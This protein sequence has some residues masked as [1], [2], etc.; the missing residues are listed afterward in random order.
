M[1]RYETG[2]LLKSHALA[3]V[4]AV[5]CQGV[6]G[7]GIAYQFKEAF[8]KNYNIYRDS[9]KKGDFKIGSILIVH[10]QGKLIVNFPSKD[11]WK[12]KS[13]YEYIAI[14]LE[15]LK[16]EIIKR[17]IDSIAIP[18]LGC[19]NGGLEWEVVQSMIIKTLGNLESVEIILFAP[20]AKEK[21]GLDKSAISVKHLLV[22][23]VF[24]RISNKYRYAL[25]SVFYMCSLLNNGSYFDFSIKHGRPYSQEL[26]DVINGLKELRGKYK[27]DFEGFIENYINTHL[28]KD[29]EAEFRRFLPSLNFSIEFLNEFSSKEDFVL[30]SKVLSD[31]Y[32]DPLVSY[33]SLD[34]EAEVLEKLI[35]KGIIHKNLLSE[36]E[37]VKF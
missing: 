14:G 3:L 17:N 7:K 32:D 18:P 27:Q 12:K 9:C 21:T 37:L 29:M 36:Y 10:E 28:T 6:M 31:V 34:R 35:T 5:N 33:D 25:N 20:P 4:N 22:H 15:K 16:S 2:N 19:G 1:I 13:Q 26:D 30:L 8:P 23:Y 11:N 24:G